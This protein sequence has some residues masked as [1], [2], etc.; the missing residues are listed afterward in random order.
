MWT[1]SSRNV[2]ILMP[3]STVSI[4]N[5]VTSGGAR[6]FYFVSNLTVMHTNTHSETI[7]RRCLATVTVNGLE[8]ES[9]SFAEAVVNVKGTV[10]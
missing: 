3:N 6:N 10:L 7:R 8:T 1:T 2:E 9:T 4:V 5:S